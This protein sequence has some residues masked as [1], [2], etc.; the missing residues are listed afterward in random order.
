MNHCEKQQFSEILSLGLPSGNRISGPGE[1]IRIVREQV[2]YLISMTEGKSP[3][4]SAR[5][6]IIGPLDLALASL[7]GVSRWLIKQ[8]ACFLQPYQKEIS[9]AE[10]KRPIIRALTVYFSASA[11]MTG[12]CKVDFEAQ[13]LA[14]TS[15]RTYTF[16]MRL[17]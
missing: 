7:A 17:Q 15:W 16:N 8:V 12:N 3:T 4:V 13:H 14:P 2:G 5:I 9:D 6:R 10:S 11:P 1:V